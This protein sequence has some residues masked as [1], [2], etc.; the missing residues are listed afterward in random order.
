MKPSS[1]AYLAEGRDV[2]P[3][4][5]LDIKKFTL[6]S[7]ESPLWEDFKMGSFIFLS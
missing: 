3:I 4:Y 1:N 5:K 6:P 2:K 7:Y